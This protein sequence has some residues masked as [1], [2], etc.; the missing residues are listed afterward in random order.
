MAAVEVVSS[1]GRDVES[2][3]NS[4]AGHQ[5]RSRRGRRA[6]DT[7]CRSHQNRRR[8]P[9]AHEPPNAASLSRS[10]GVARRS[11]CARR[12][13]N[14]PRM[15]AFSL[16]DITRRA[17]GRPH[18]ISPFLYEMPVGIHAGFET[19]GPSVNRPG[20]GCVTADP[21]AILVFMRGGGSR[22]V[23]RILAATAVNQFGARSRG[24]RG[25]DCFGPKSAP[26]HHCARSLAAGGKIPK[27]RKSS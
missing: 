20:G 4:P 2:G 18:Q 14:D 5:A 19:A 9:N 12:L 8:R 10:V 13:V 7:A 27:A 23:S 22:R 11:S 15:T 24:A 6:P 3:G 17:S 26:G 16:V 25:L 21:A 1:L